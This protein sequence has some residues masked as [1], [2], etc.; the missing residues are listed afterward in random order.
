[1]GPNCVTG[2][3]ITH[4]VHNGYIQYSTGT[5]V[6]QPM[7]ASYNQRKGSTYVIVYEKAHK[8]ISFIQCLYF[9]Y[10]IRRNTVLV[11]W[12]PSCRTYACKEGESA[13]YDSPSP[14][15]TDT[16]KISP[17]LLLLSTYY[18]TSTV[19]THFFLPKE[20]PPL[21]LLSDVGE[22]WPRRRE[23][24][25]DSI[26]SRVGRTHIFLPLYILREGY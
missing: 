14:L 5:M 18:Y 7:I 13:I 22:I 1:M 9:S 15:D 25:Q 26:F 3:T 23:E 20:N 10:K 21:L 17:F 6:R 11:G 2:E 19:Y 4:M 12:C 8:C 16:A 24:R